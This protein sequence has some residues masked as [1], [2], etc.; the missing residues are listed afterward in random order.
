MSEKKQTKDYWLSLAQL[1]GGDG[2]ETGRAG[3]DGGE[4]VRPL[5][6]VTRRGFLRAAGFSF[7][8]AMA[9]GCYR[10]PVEKAIPFLN[11]PEEIIPGVARYYASTCGGCAAGCGLLVK[12]RDGRPIKLEGN[13]DHPLSRGGLC[14]VGQASVLGLYDSQRLRHPLKDGARTTWSETDTAITARLAEIR[15][16][17]GRVRFLS[18]TPSGPSGVRILDE[19]LQSFSDARRVISEP[20]SCSAILEA[21]ELTH[22]SRRLPH[23]RFDRAVLIV[24]FD[25][26]FL[27]TWISPVEFTAGYSAGRRPEAG[28]GIDEKGAHH[29]NGQRYSEH[30]QFESRMSI[31]GAKADTRYPV[32]PGE[33][34]PVVSG[35]TKRVASLAGAPFDSGDTAVSTVPGDV[36]DR[37]ARRLWNARGRGLVVCGSQ[38]V[39][40][41]VLVNFLNH[42]LGNYGATLDL[43]RP[44]GQR[45]ADDGALQAL[46]GEINQGD[47]DALFIHDAN[48]VFDLPGGEALA[49]SI[50]AIPLVVSFAPRLDETSR[51]AHFV[52][53]DHH[54]LES[55]G[56]VEAVHGV[57]S[58]FQP[59]V[60]PLGNTRALVESL[61]AWSGRPRS[62]RE[63][64]I[65]QWPDPAFREQTLHDGIARL[66]RASLETGPFRSGAVSPIGPTETPGAGELQLVLYHKVGLLDGRHAFNPWLQELPD[67]ITKAVW[68]NYACLSPAA[69][70][71]AG[72][73]EGDVVRVAAGGEGSGIPAIELPVLIQ[74]GQHDG[75]VAVA[76]GYGSSLSKRFA[77]VGP[78]WI[79]GRSSV[80]GNGL[81]GT[82]AAEGTLRFA[83]SAV[84]VSGT[85]RRHWLALTQDHHHITVPEHLAP[86]GGRVRPNIQETSL[87][88]LHQGHDNGHGGHHFEGELWPEDHKYEGHHWGMVIDLS[89]CTGC[90]G[91]VV[92]C[93][94]ENNVPVVGKDEVRLNR[95]MHWIRIDRYYSEQDG[96]VDVAQQPMMCHHCDNAP[97]ET[98]CPVLAT[99][100]SEEGLNQQVYNRC[101]GTRYCSNNC[102]FKVRRFNWFNYPHNDQLQNMTLNPDVT[103]RSRGVMEKCSFCVQRIQEARIKARLDG[104]EMADGAVQPA[105]QQSCPAGAIVFG[106]MNDPESRVARLIRSGRHFRVLE[107]INVRPSVGYLKIVRNRPERG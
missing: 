16:R 58:F 57:I 13:P 90:A 74:P 77:D 86:K 104:V 48:P 34:G 38:D 95:E 1:D 59:V 11:Q 12:N 26:D 82:N 66:E 20:L 9:S 81:V 24:G 47:V 30:I 107:E 33:L 35:L 50:E 46:L 68:D 101:V 52:C 4:A 83:G 27:G 39:R 51:L 62:A 75:V 18:G 87:A 84:R 99:V 103:V 106:D 37:L 55:W 80:G 61:V 41:Q 15:A 67:P 21:H 19:F 32:L 71:A 98:V 17:G 22:G 45:A 91:C 88:D 44:S 3:Q 25:A 6:P 65:E 96:V 14:A 64:L 53:P 69:A 97:C 49:R 36:L 63:I 72:V 78:Q 85:G 93:Q 76:L 73:T 5:V 43:S 56:D 31:T 29:E 54:F 100:H 60:T 2:R 102:P 8:A 42:L 7:A 70:E 10:A 92:A 89:A 94:V 79:E 28:E 105:C 23:Y 40:V